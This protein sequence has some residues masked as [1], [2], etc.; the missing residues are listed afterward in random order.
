MYEAPETLSP[1]EKKYLRTENQRKHSGIWTKKNGFR[2]SISRG[3]NTHKKWPGHI[4][5][6]ARFIFTAW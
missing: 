5:R 4:V 1:I 2:L 6:Q 3:K